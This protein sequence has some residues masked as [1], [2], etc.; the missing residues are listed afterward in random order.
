MSI[1][2]SAPQEWKRKNFPWGKTITQF[3]DYDQ[4]YV[5]DNGKTQ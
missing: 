4:S 5:D 1:D 2:F 3:F